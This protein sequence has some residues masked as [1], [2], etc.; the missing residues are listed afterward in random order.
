ML[1]RTLSSFSYVGVSKLF[2]QVY[3]L[4][5]SSNSLKSK[6]FIITI[7]KNGH[8]SLYLLLLFSF[9]L[10]IILKSPPAT[11][12]RVSVVHAYTSSLKKSSFST[13]L[14]V[15]FTAINSHSK[16]SSVLFSLNFMKKLPRTIF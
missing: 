8:L 14:A 13:S 11:S 5:D 1:A 16:L 3:Y 2:A 9:G 15:P 7:N 10:L 4:S 6:L 12:G